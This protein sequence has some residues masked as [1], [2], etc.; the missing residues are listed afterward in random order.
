[1]TAAEIGD[2]LG[3]H[4]N[5]VLKWLREHEIERRT[6]PKFNHE[7][8]WRDE[9]TLRELYV[10]R[11][12][13]MEEISDELGVSI[14][15]VHRWLTKYDI[16]T[17]SHAQSGWQNYHANSYSTYTVDTSGYP[18]WLSNEFGYGGPHLKVHRLLAVAE[19]GFEEVSEM[20]VHHKNG[21][22]WDNRPE[23]LE[24]M[25]SSEHSKHH[26]DNKDMELYNME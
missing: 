2:E 17:R 10:E 18:V 4:E 5:T 24:L 20:V 15:G 26:Y 22:R 14:D 8:P 16:P 9:D 6:G 7:A 3:C 12:M 23:N 25:T 11:E 13:T 1:M 21:I 19:Y